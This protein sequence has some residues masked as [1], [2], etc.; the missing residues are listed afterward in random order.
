MSEQ[1]G[2]ILWFQPTGKVSKVGIQT[3]IPISKTTTIDALF[4]TY[5]KYTEE[6]K[7]NIVVEST[8]RLRGLVEV[9]PNNT[10]EG[11][12]S[13]YPQIDNDFS[14]T[15]I[16]S[17]HEQLRAKIEM[18]LSNTMEGDLE[19]YGIGQEKF[20]SQIIVSQNETF[21]AKIKLTPM[22]RMRGLV[23]LT[24]LPRFKKEYT[25]IKDSFIRSDVPRVNYGDLPTM[26]VG[27]STTPYSGN[28]LAEFLALLQFDLSDLPEGA[29]IEKATLR[30]R[31][32]LEREDVNFYASLNT[33]DW[34]E[35][36]VAWVNKPNVTKGGMRGTSIDGD[37]VDIDILDLAKSWVERE[38]KENNYGLTLSLPDI[39]QSLILM[40]KEIGLSSYIPKLII[41][42]Y[43]RDAVIS[44]GES[45]VNATIQVEKEMER[46]LRSRVVIK[47]YYE[48]EPL[49]AKLELDNPRDFVSTIS[50]TRNALKSTVRVIRTETYPFLARLSIKGGGESPLNSTIIVSK[51]LLVSTLTIAEIDTI[52]AKVYV[53]GHEKFSATV[54]VSKESVPSRITV[55]INEGI[56]STIIVERGCSNKLKANLR[57][58]YIKDIYTEM[59]VATHSVI[60]TNIIV[61]TEKSNIL[62]SKIIVENTT[63]RTLSSTVNLRYESELFLRMKVIS[64]NFPARLSIK[65]DDTSPLQATI[66]VASFLVS[67][68]ASPIEVEN[69]RDFK[70]IIIVDEEEDELSYVFIM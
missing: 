36:T 22:N 69:P 50:V 14:A 67:D 54:T 38:I 62:N 26:E 45:G 33:S 44:I 70:S 6:F 52:P 3:N 35:D 23:N 4:G 18:E 31:T 21:P 68:L 29:I 10:M 47:S 57:L 51:E 40:A 56:K 61:E 60:S 30:L 41:T 19:V 59:T 64:P 28:N 63:S 17:T 65:G 55:A 7:A 20:V 42:Y 25:P 34:K 27:K 24:P 15:I 53:Q 5:P 11:E 39:E 43:D 13:I 58:G 32:A 46:N 8:S 16:V 12:F 66:Q 2:L 9:D 1:D 48:T 37:T 49:P